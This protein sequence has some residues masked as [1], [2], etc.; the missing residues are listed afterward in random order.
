MH[1]CLFVLGLA[2]CGSTGEPAAEP[3]VE[4]AS[5]PTFEPTAFAVSVHGHGRPIIFIPGLGCPGSVWDATVGHLDGFESHVLT[6]AGFAGLPS[7]EGSLVATTKR[8][9]A[10]YIRAHA[11]D[12]PVIVGHSLGGYLAY[13]LA[14]AEPDLVGPTIVVDS[15]AALGGDD[16]AANISAGKVARDLWVNASDDQYPQQI[17]DTFSEMV[18]DP[19]RLDLATV[20]RSDRRAIG[21]A[22]Y[23]MFTTDLRPGLHEIQVPVLVV[24]AD[25]GLQEGMR[26]QADAVP[27]HQVVVVPHTKHFVFVDDPAGF[28][29]VIDPFL[30]SH[31]NPIASR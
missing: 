1:P 15:G 24:L 19:K 21:G 20:A 10:S 27:D 22:I 3:A 28:F 11:L 4:Q 17:R 25:G 7:I 26:A 16:P 5:A 12:R 30:A 31:G 29:A 14:E 9:L 6:L 18:T 2:A 23:E 8:E 13:A